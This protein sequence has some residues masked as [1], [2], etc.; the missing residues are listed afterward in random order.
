MVSTRGA[1]LVSILLA[2]GLT[3]SACVGSSVALGTAES[4]E[5]SEVVLRDDVG[6]PYACLID[7]DKVGVLTG[8][9]QNR[10]WTATKVEVTDS[11][12][13]LVEFSLPDSWLPS[14]ADM[15]TT[16][17]VLRIP[18]GVDR[19]PL[20]IEQTFNGEPGNRL[21]LQPVS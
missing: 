4:C 9:S 10:Q 12:A 18:E 3:L 8:G 2:C 6:D 7:E 13:M 5:D 17:H 20:V 16:L 14:T 1:S 21:E 15:T 19:N 11:S